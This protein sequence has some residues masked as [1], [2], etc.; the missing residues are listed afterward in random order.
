MKPII[1]G[2]KGLKLLPEEIDFFKE[3]NPYGYILFKRNCES[4]SQVQDLVSHLKSLN[5]RPFVPILIDQE[6]GRVSRL[7]APVFKEFPPAL[8][9]IEQAKG[10]IDLACKLVFDNYYAIALELAELGINVNCAPMADILFDFSHDIIG[11]RSFGRS[12]AIVSRL[13]NAC[14]EGLIAGKVLPVIKHIPGHGRATLDSH[15]DLPIVSTDY[16]TLDSTDFEVFRNLSSQSFAMTAHIIYEA[17]DKTAAATLS[18]PVI[19]IIRDKINFKNI[20]MTDDLSM[21]ALSALSLKER[22]EKSLA[23]GCDILLHCNGEIDEMRE[24]A[25]IDC[26]TPDNIIAYTNQLLK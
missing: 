2:L 17:I 7:K 13:A 3:I 10:D 9:F 21:K 25:N 15:F 18:K 26:N 6:G 22:A 4:K 8:S 19:D 1:F 14:C 23:S 5:V 20:L 11:D 12:H 16:A 24:I